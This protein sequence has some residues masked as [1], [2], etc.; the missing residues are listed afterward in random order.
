MSEQITTQ[1]TQKPTPPWMIPV[2]I[3][4]AGLIVGAAL[5]FRPGSNAPA[6]KA[7]SQAQVKQDLAVTAKTIGV[8]DVNNATC[9]TAENKAAVE[10]DVN[11]GNAI[12]VSGTPFLVFEFVEASG[13]R[14]VAVPGAIPQAT[15]EQILKD[16]KLPQGFPETPLENYTF[17]NEADHKTSSLTGKTVRIVEYSDL[18][19]PYCKRVHPE[20]E[21]IVA[22]HPE[23]VWI[24]RHFPLLN[25]HPNAGIKAEASECVAKL[26]GDEAFW[27]FIKQVMT[28]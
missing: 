7:L 22:N 13:V 23:V 15:I 3:V 16:K 17:A 25:L 5:F 28:E 8:R 21:A 14:A 26:G 10:E 6:P 4:I 9:F 18:D 20:L 1:S 2:S 12:G 19:C 27:K 24:Y 11:S